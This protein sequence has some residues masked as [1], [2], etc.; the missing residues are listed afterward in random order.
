[1]V[2]CVRDSITYGSGISDRLN[3]SY[4]AQLERLG[5]EYDPAWEV[6]NF[7]VSGARVYGRAVQP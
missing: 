3:N 7:G 4:P 6:R 1:L 2:A 5:R